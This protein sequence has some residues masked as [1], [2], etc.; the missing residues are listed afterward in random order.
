MIQSLVRWVRR[1]ATTANSSCLADSVWPL[2][3]VSNQADGISEGMLLHVKWAVLHQTPR[4]LCLCKYLFFVH[5]NKKMSNVHWSKSNMCKKT[6][7]P[8]NGNGWNTMQ[9]LSIHCAGGRYPLRPR[10]EV[11]VKVRDTMRFDLRHEIELVRKIRPCCPWVYPETFSWL[12]PAIPS[13]P[14]AQIVRRK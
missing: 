5:T 2:A 6:N 10:L 9:T 12:K 13:H 8:Q 7:A 1:S 4:S 3:S 14:W 11:R